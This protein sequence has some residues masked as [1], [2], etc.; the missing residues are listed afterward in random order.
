MNPTT[1]VTSPPTGC[2]LVGRRFTLMSWRWAAD[3]V[4]DAVDNCEADVLVVE[5][6][7]TCTWPKQRP[8][9]CPT[10]SVSAGPVAPSPGSATG[11][12]SRAFPAIR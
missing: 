4:A 5:A 1:E 10:S 2:Y 6:L 12:R 3:E 11:A 9:S 8:N 7:P